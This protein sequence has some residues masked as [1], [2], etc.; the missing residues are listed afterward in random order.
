[1]RFTQK[2]LLLLIAI[3][4]ISK[5]TGALELKF[6][7]GPNDLAPAPGWTRV[8]A[9]Q[10]KSPDND[11]G[12]EKHWG[13]DSLV[14]ENADE[15]QLRTA[16]GAERNTTDATFTAKIPDGV[17]K[18]T[19]SVGSNVPSE[20]RDGQC[21]EIN[22]RA[23]LPPPGVGGWGKL[24]TRTLPAVVENGILKVR[25]FTPGEKATQRLNIYAMTVE[26]AAA[27]EA[28]ALKERFEALKDPALAEEKKAVVDGVEIVE[29]GR[30]P[31]RRAP[32]WTD[33]EKAAGAVFFAKDFSGDILDETVPTRAEIKNATQCAAAAG[34]TRSFVIGLHAL[35]DIDIED[36]RM[37]GFPGMESDLYTLTTVYRSPFDMNSKVGV[38]TAELL[39]HRNRFSLKKGTTSPLYGTVKVP[40]GMAAGLYDGA[41]AVKT[42]SGTELRYPV[43]LEVLPVKLAEADK[44]FML[45]ADS[46]RW[47]SMPAD[48]VKAEIR[49][50]AEHGINA[51]SIVTAP[52]AFPLLEDENGRITGADF[53]KLGE[54]LKYAVSLGINRQLDFSSTAPM[55]WFLPEFGINHR[56]TNATHEYGKDFTIRHP[57]KA[58]VTHIDT[59]GFQGIWTPRRY[60]LSVNYHLTGNARAQ[61]VLST[62]DVNRRKSQPELRGELK[63]NDSFSTAEWEVDAAPPTSNV[64]FSLALTGEGEL[65]IREI[66]LS[67]LDR[68]GLNYF[69]NGRLQRSIDDFDYNREWPEAFKTAFQSAVK[70]A[71]DEGR[72]LGF[73]SVDVQGTDEAGNNPK[74]ERK[75]VQELE[76]V[77][78][79]GEKA[80]C[81]LSP[82]L[83]RKAVG[84]LDELCFYADL[85][86]NSKTAAETIKFYRELGKKIFSISAGTYAGQ[87]LSIMNNRYNSGFYLA[88]NDVDGLL[89]WTFSR[90]VNDP[91][92]DFDSRNKD[93]A[94]VY[95]PRT[96]GGEPVKSIAWE[97]I[98]EGITD[99]RYLKSLRQAIARA[100]QD[101]RKACAD[102][103][104][105][106]LG[107]LLQSVPEYGKFDE[108]SFNDATADRL[109]R[110][111]ALGIMAADGK[112]IFDT[113]TKEAAAKI[114]LR[115]IPTAKT[116]SDE[117]LIPAGPK[118]LN[119]T[120][121]KPHFANVPFD[122]KAA[123]SVQVSCDSENLY[124]KVEASGGD[125]KNRF[126]GEELSVY[127]N[128][129]IELLLDTRY[130]RNS[131]FQFAFDRFG[132]KSDMR[133]SGSRNS[134]NS[135]FAVNYG[136]GI[137]R[138]PSWNAEWT[139]KTAPVA[140]GWSADVVIPLKVFGDCNLRWGMLIGRSGF[141]TTVSSPQIGYFDQPEK[142]RTVTLP[143]EA[144]LNYCSLGDFAFGRLIANLRFTALAG[145]KVVVNEYDADNKKSS[146]QGKVRQDGTCAVEYRLTEKSARLEVLALDAEGKVRW[147]HN[148]LLNL[149]PVLAVH[150][151]EQVFF[152]GDSV[153][154]AKAE[155][156]VTDRAAAESVLEFKLS[157]RQG[158]I[159]EAQS[160]A[161]SQDVRVPLKNLPDGFY[162]FSVRLRE[163]KRICGAQN[164][165]I[166]KISK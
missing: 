57:D 134:G 43:K 63:S 23:V 5:I 91:F 79:A 161:G 130:D 164:M 61:V 119:I 45:V 65:K 149:P 158:L 82:D 47:Q 165:T 13:R 123:T 58:S 1:M 9:R 151:P 66:R 74:T 10:L 37:E 131:W 27:A 132:N 147:K 117:R 85:L 8:H 36:I 56:A 114:E 44:V 29:T 77:R 21:V 73:A 51:L 17:Y 7:F 42:R 78:A 143:G 145:G 48:A 75:E 140:G 71:C 62:Y 76:N 86:G 16:C 136:G 152:G 90:P 103:A 28:G 101:G 2:K 55:L 148:E 104:R 98:R 68:P 105:A 112:E 160:K 116:T 81:N 84:H 87:N 26:S 80:F 69:A 32:A 97:G 121:F 106:I 3:I 20:G 59:R 133:A 83:G 12:W 150:A 22:G 154:K 70:A 19:V 88:L 39:E 92:N 96:P 46:R 34:E 24:V 120:D 4:F 144:G 118:G 128:D 35:E 64:R 109:R 110:L 38:K 125:T 18:V 52:E 6:D 94:L 41:V 15:V 100:E 142:F 124:L 122:G 67:P 95:P 31:I 156:H 126:N 157:G 159:G 108:R 129:H 138:D 89:L 33:E 102:Q 25:F 162:E 113:Q 50:M 146:F 60:K 115:P 153:F 14:R 93:Y 137:V 139:V 99:Y 155:V 111:A 49:D 54:Y 163:G 30:R 53:D 141:G 127:A 135:I 11:Y 40:E 107:C 72:K 166:V